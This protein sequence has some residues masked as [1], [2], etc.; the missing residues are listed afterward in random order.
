MS[1]G[2]ASPS[3]ALLPKDAKGHPEVAF[4]LVIERRVAMNID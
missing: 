4:V 1:L 3:T 2:S